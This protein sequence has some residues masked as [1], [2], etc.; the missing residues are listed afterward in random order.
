MEHPDDTVKVLNLRLDERLHQQLAAEAKRSVRSVNG[1]I[2]FRLR[3]SIERDSEAQA[4]GGIR[5]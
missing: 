1:E 3:E 5:P 4:G 2:I